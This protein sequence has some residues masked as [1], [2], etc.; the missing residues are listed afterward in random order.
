MAKSKQEP[1]K[2]RTN[3]AGQ[4]VQLPLLAASQ[5]T[6]FGRSAI[7]IVTGCNGR[8]RGDAHPCLRPCYW[9]N[10]LM[11][12]NLTVV[13]VSRHSAPA[14]RSN[15]SDETLVVADQDVPQKKSVQFLFEIDRLAYQSWRLLIS[16]F[17]CICRERCR[18]LRAFADGR[19]HSSK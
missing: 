18:G 14:T 5:V 6:C 13:S 7:A 4:I 16:A 9:S 3:D 19:S 17:T 11:S 15:F 8:F 10:L 12:A 2:P 1:T